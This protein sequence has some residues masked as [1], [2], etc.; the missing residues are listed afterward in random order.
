MKGI[1]IPS[2]TYNGLQNLIPEYLKSLMGLNLSLLSAIATPEAM[3]AEMAG[4]HIRRATTHSILPAQYSASAIPES[5]IT[6]DMKTVSA[7][8]LIL[9]CLNLVLFFFIDFKPFLVKV[10]FRF[11]A[12]FG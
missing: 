6:S 9:G 8:L 7:F 11:N 1:T 4:T 5:K 2:K 10:K 3:N 12:L